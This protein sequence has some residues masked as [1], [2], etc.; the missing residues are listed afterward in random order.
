MN[1]SIDELIADLN[2][3]VEWNKISE[4]CVMAGLTVKKIPEE[5]RQEFKKAYDEYFNIK[6]HDKIPSVHIDIP[7]KK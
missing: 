6:E 1:Y 2:N 7:R 4:K 3:R 5:K